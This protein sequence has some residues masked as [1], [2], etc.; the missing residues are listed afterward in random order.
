MKKLINTAATSAT[1]FL[2]PLFASAQSLA[3]LGNLITSLNNIVNRLVPLAITVAMLAFFWGLIKY[4]YK[5]SKEDVKKGRSMMIYGILALF[6][7]VS[8]WGLVRLLQTAFGIGPNETAQTPQAP[9][10]NGLQQSGTPNVYYNSRGQ[11]VDGSGM[12]LY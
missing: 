12:P 2:I 10:S 11:E 4:L 8:I 3:P 9:T 5:G 6:V 7:M 1:L